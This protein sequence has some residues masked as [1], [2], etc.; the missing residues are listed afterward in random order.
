M[1]YTPKEVITMLREYQNDVDLYNTLVAE[2]N[3]DRNVISISAMQYGEESLMPKA[4]N[5]SNPTQKAAERLLIKDGSLQRTAKKLEFINQRS[6]RL[7]KNQHIVTFALRT[8]GY[9]C[10][11]IAGILNVQRTRVQNIINEIAQLMCKSDEDYRIYCKK[12]K[13]TPRY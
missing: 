5:I 11:Y 10:Q 8:Q 4:D 6:K 13:L 1:G 3:E 2:Q 12:K 7:H 9:T